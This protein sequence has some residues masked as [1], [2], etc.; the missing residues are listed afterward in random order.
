MSN[1]ASDG[2]DDCSEVDC[3]AVASSNGSVL[4]AS[5]FSGVYVGGGTEGM[6]MVDGEK[7]ALRAP[8]AMLV[9]L[10]GHLHTDAIS[11]GGQASDY[12]ESSIFVAVPEATIKDVRVGQN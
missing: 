1:C 9:S 2:N 6:D 12:D 8:Q 7:D 11:S 3:S 10:H 5:S 4:S